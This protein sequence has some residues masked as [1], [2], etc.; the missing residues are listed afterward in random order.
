[1]K[2]FLKLVL[3]TALLLTL[4]ACQV[5]GRQGGIFSGT[6]V[7]EGEHIFQ[8]GDQVQ[9]I[10]VI[11]DGRV[12]VEP[13]ARVEGAVFM[14]DGA[15]EMDGV[16]EQDLSAIGGRV[17]VGPQA[18]IGGDLR[19]SDVDLDLSPGARVQGQA[20]TGASSGLAPQDM[21]PS[22]TLRQQLIWVIPQSLALA[23]L[24]T[25]LARY[26]P[27][28]LARV[29]RAAVGHPVV[30]A[31]MGLLAG[32]VGLVLVVVMA[33]TLI[34]LPVTFLSLAAGFLSIGYGWSGMGMA[35][36]DWLA[37]RRG[38]DLSPGRTAFLGAFLFGLILNLAALL[39]YLG[40]L[41]GILA[42]TISLGGVL[43]TRFGLREF[44]PE[45]GP[46]L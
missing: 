13:G 40:A 36:G 45:T 39:P 30:S 17:S 26:L 29:R 19:V 10:L 8:A 15:L 43:L 4:S 20:L 31:A 21:F 5:Q 38:W 28:P 22:R 6:L 41:T 35:L 12:A 7:T 32:V 27:G 18:L 14:L 2:S 24:A 1:M 34:L 3:S 23:L 11:L 33:F 16:V 9:G 42:L 44:V 37:G 25:L 46:E